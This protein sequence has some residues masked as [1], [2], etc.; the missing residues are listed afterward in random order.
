MRRLYCATDIFARE[1]TAVT[2]Y[3]DWWNGGAVQRKGGMKNCAEMDVG[4]PPGSSNTDAAFPVQAPLTV[5]MFQT[6]EQNGS[7]CNVNART[8]GPQVVI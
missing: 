7:E 6:E 3:G 4:R 2:A 8:I 1:S 5:K